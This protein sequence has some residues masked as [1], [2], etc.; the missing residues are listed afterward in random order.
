MGRFETSWLAFEKFAIFFSFVVT[1]TL[2]V[3]L[4][5]LGFG[6]WQVAPS[7]PGLRD[8]TLCPLIAQVDGL[9]TDFDNAVI[10]RTISISQTIP[11]VFD[12]TL[13]QNTVVKL[14]KSVPLNRAATMVLPG[15]GGQINGT[16]SLS[17]PAGQALPV[18]L[19]MPVPI[20]QNLP[21]NM[22]VL[23]SIPL[24]ETELG[25]VTGQLKDLLTP[26]TKLLSDVLHCPKS[27]P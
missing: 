18:H 1:M 5:L 4:L 20:R 17:L 6:L 7:L 15:G 10:T 22:D 14:T 23:V 9:V 16:V 25:S 8:G 26:Y 24:K 12:I 13:D 11:V 2:V 27:S 21:V 19:T 3:V